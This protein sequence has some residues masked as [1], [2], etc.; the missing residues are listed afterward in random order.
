MKA[1]VLGRMAVIGLCSVL[2]VGCAGETE[3][4]AARGEASEGSETSGTPTESGSGETPKQ[5]GAVTLTVWSEAAGNE[6]L[7]ELI[8]SFKEEYAGQAEFDIRIEEASDADTRGNVL[9][10][11]HNAADVF[12]LADDQMASLVA[13]GALAQVPNAEEIK[14]ANAEGAVA[15]ACVG[16]TLYAYPMTADNGYFLYYNKN[17]FSEEDVQT[18]DRIL[19]VA[20]E[21][22]KKF[23]MQWDSGWYLY[24]FFG[25]T[26]LDFG[27]NEDGVTN[28]CNWN[29]V[30]GPIKGVDIA[31]AMLA[32]AAHPGFISQP[33][34]DF[35]EGARAGTAI[36]G[37]SGVWN[38]MEIREIWGDNYGAKKLPTYT[39]AGQ[40][41]QMASFVGYKMIGVNAY[42]EHLDW[43]LKFA[44]WITNE[45]NQVLRF[46][47]RNQGPSNIN[48][49]S[50]DAVKQ[51]PA[52]QAVM[53]QAQYGVLQRVGNNYWTPSSEFGLKMAAGNPEGKELQEILDTLVAGITASAVN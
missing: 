13:G 20:A 38:A 6:L 8:Q 31:E 2:A 5:E 52:I 15:A 24:T 44:D 49:A 42:S 7:E 28:H 46:E 35:I 14:K 10:D 39:C 40:Q 17:Y 1:K 48:A 3:P 16:D 9:G 19:D 37:V 43:A 26:G 18:L 45:E 33:D 53:E 21:N 23:S 4:A 12:S 22:E 41:I 11:V 47:R 32:I 50:S 36:A 29:T 34:G 51:V 27:I 30:E 25:N